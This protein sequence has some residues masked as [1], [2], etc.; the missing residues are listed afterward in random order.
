MEKKLEFEDLINNQSN[1][2]ILKKL[3]QNLSFYVG[4]NDCD[5]AENFLL[6]AVPISIAKKIDQEIV[7][8]CALVS[9]LKVFRFEHGGPC[10]GHPPYLICSESYRLD[11]HELKTICAAVDL[12]SPGLVTQIQT[13]EVFSDDELAKIRSIL[14][15]N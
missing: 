9:G 13:S 15:A 12:E 10:I 6:T 8:L 7:A 11:A 1:F 5:F 4:V 2:D 14:D 3:C